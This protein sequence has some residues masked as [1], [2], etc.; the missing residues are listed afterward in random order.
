MPIERRF[1]VFPKRTGS[2]VR[3]I[4]TP[5]GPNRAF[6]K[7]IKTLLS[8]IVTPSYL[9]SRVGFSIRH[10]AEFHQENRYFLSVDIREFYQ[11]T[12]SDFVRGFF[13]KKL[14]MSGTLANVLTELL[15]YGGHIPTGSSASQILAYFS[16]S[17]MFDAI[18]R[19]S[20]KH[21]VQFSLYVDDMV[22]SSQGPLPGSLLNQIVRELRKNGLHLKFSKVSFKK[23]NEAKRITGCILSSSGELKVPNR[24][25]I[26]VI[27]ILESVP[28]IRLLPAPD[29]SSLIG[30]ISQAQQIEPGIF[31][32]TRRHALRIIQERRLLRKGA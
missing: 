10:N 27:R 14:K 22:F 4:E 32:S 8:Q 16:Y 21:G 7:R 20:N 12:R 31:E 9:K 17:E 1:N 2:K 19:I 13:R 29:L 15:T 18:Q 26:K 6:H 23:G 11:S 25:R 30:C 28:N 24:T 5:I 3:I